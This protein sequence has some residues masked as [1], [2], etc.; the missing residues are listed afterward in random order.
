MDIVALIGFLAACLLAA[1]TGIFFRPGQWYAGLAKPSWQPPNTVFAP[2]WSTLYLMIA[3]AGWLVWR[4]DGFGLPLALYFVQLVL[5]GVWTTI[6]FGRH[7]LDL[8]FYELVVL[9]IAIAA[10]IALFAPVSGWAA[11][12]LVPYLA[13]VTFAGALNFAVWR[14]NPSPPA[15]RAGTGSGVSAGS[16]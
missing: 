8:A 16:G 4:A 7:R 1:S 5:N 6:F 2:V 12:L 9:W 13:W 14:L 3:V 15:G 11:A 10:T